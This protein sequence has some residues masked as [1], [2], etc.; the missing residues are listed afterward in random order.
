LLGLG[1]GSSERRPAVRRLS[2]SVLQRVDGNRENADPACG[3]DS[4]ST[5]VRRGQPPQDAS[6]DESRPCP[7]G[8]RRL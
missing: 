4:L 3:V 2:P 6:Q 5:A 8:P 7:D 1:Q